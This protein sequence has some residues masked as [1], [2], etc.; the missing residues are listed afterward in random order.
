MNNPKYKIALKSPMHTTKF[1]EDENPRLLKGQI[2]IE[3][4]SNNIRKAKVGDG[5]N[6]WTDLPYIGETS[7]SINNIIKE[8]EKKADKTNTYTK[9]EVDSALDEKADKSNTYTKTEVNT[10]LAKK[11]DKVTVDEIIDTY[12]LKAETERLNS[13]FLEL[14][15]EISDARIV[16]DQ[17][18][19][20]LK[21]ALS[22]VSNTGYEKAKKYT[23]DVLSTYEAVDWV[24]VDG[25][26]E[27]GYPNI[28]NPS[29]S[30]FY[31]VSNKA[32]TG[33]DKYVWI[34]Y[35]KEDS[36]IDYKWDVF[37]SATTLVVDSLE[38]ISQ[39]SEDIDYI[40]NNNDGCLYYKYIDNEFV[41][42]GGSTA[43]FLDGSRYETIEVFLKEIAT[44]NYFTDYYIL[45]NQIY[46]H[47]RYIDDKWI[48]IN[49]TFNID[50]QIDEIQTRVS[51]LS[52]SV[53]INGNSI[54]DIQTQLES[55]ESG[56]EYELDL[57][58]EENE[59]TEQTINKLILKCDGVDQDTIV[60][61]S[62]G[63]SGG[64]SSKI[65]VDMITPSSFVV[66]EGQPALIEY[67]FSS[68]D[69]DGDF[70]AGTYL[71][72]IDNVPIQG[73][74][75][76]CITGLNSFDI[77]PYLTY[78]D[79]EFTLI[80]TDTIGSIKTKRWTVRKVDIRLESTFND[81]NTKEAGKNFEFTFTPY[82]AGIDKTVHF[83][84]DGVELP[85]STFKSSAVAQIYEIPAQQHGAHLLECWITAVINGITIET[86][87][88]Y[89]DIICVDST[90][91]I[92]IIGCS[93][94]CLKVDENAVFNENIVYYTM[95]KDGL[96]EIWNG[97][98]S[99]WETRPILYFGNVTANQYDSTTIEYVVY[100]PN[101][102]TSYVTITTDESS[103]V[104]KTDKL[105]NVISYKTDVAGTHTIKFSIG[106]ND[107]SN[108]YLIMKIM[109][110][111][112]EI[113][114]V[115]TGRIFDFNPSG[116]SNA[117]ID[118]N[119]PWH[120]SDNS[121]IK[122]TVSDGFD[123]N[124]G[125]FQLDE[126][127][128][129]YFCVKSGHR[130]Y[131]SHKL[132]E[133]D[134]RKNGSHFK[135][136]FKT[137]NV[138]NINA[139]F[140]S[141]FADKVGLEMKA[142]EAN[143]MTASKTLNIP[144]SEEDIIEFEYNV[145]PIDTTNDSAKA[146]IMIYEDGVP[147][148]PM[149]YDNTHRLYQNTNPS[150][151]TIGSDDCDI[152]IYRMKANDSSLNDKSVIL[153]FI[154]DALNSDEM[155]SRY[156]RNQ[157]YDSSTGILTPES[158]ANACPDLKIIKIECPR[159]TNNKSD[160]VK[161]TNI[162]CI[163]KGGDPILD[164]WYATGA[165][166]S[167][168][169]TTSNEYGIAGRNLDL[170]MNTDTTVITNGV[171][172]VVNG[173]ANI[174]EGGGIVENVSLTRNSVP[175]NYFNIKVNIASSENANNALLQKRFQRFLPYKTISKFKD[176]RVK[177]TMEFVNCVVFIK[178]TG[179]GLD[180][181]GNPVTRQEF[182]DDEWHFYAI[183]N[184]GDSKKTDKTRICDEN[185]TK[186]FVNE[187]LDN[188]FPNSIFD[189]GVYNLIVETLPEVG[190]L[191]VDYYT[192]NDNGLYTHSRYINNE[193]ITVSNNVS[194]IINGATAII[195]ELPIV[196][197]KLIDYYIDNGDNTYTMYVW[198]G[199]SYSIGINRDNIEKNH[200]ATAIAEEQWIEGNIKYDSLI[201]DTFEGKDG[202]TYEPRYKHKD[203][204]IEDIKQVWF[205]FYKWVIT[206]TDDAFVN[207]FD[208]WFIKD[209]AL[210]FYLFTERYTMMDNRAK[211]SFWHWS[212]VYISQSEAD[213]DYY[214]SVKEYYEIDDAKA[215]INNGYRF[216]FW[217]YD[218]DTALGINNSG[219][220]KM[221]YGKEDIDYHNDN[222]NEGYIFNGAESTIF[223]RMRQLMHNDLMQMYQNRESA[224]AWDSN[225]LINEFDTWQ[226]QFPEE[227]WRLDIE[228]KYMRP[229]LGISID[230]SIPKIADNFLKEM[231]NGRKKY[232]RRQFEREQAI[233]MATKYLSTSVTKDENNI[234]I[235]CTSPSVA[236]VLPDYTL[237]ITPYSDMYLSVKIGNSAATQ[238]RAKAGESYDIKCHFENMTETMVL[239]YAA[240]RIQ[241]L[242]DLSRCYIDANRFGTATKLQKLII[243]SDLTG[244]SNEVLNELNIS[245]AI[246][247]E[248][249]NITNCPK[250][251]SLN[252]AE[253][254]S[255]SKVYAE[256]TNITGFAFADNGK[257][258]EAYLPNGV[259]TLS[260]R[261]LNYIN[262]FDVS[263]DNIE[264]I[265]V[266]GG[267]F[268]TNFIANEV[269]DT[270]KEIEL[271][272]INW[273]IDN[274]SILASL[275]NIEKCY[276]SGI[277]T[278]IGRITSIELENYQNKWND[279]KID[280]SQATIIPYWTVM[281]KNEDGT[282]LWI[283]YVESG[284]DVKNPKFYLGDDYYTPTKI[285]DKK[286]KYEFSNWIEESQELT[287]GQI[288][289]EDESSF[290]P[291][292]SGGN[293]I[294]IAQYTSA[295]KEFTVTWVDGH[296]TTLD[297]VTVPYGTE[298]VWDFMPPIKD[299][300][301][302]KIG[303]G[304]GIPVY[305]KAED[306]F[307]FYLFKGWNKSTG[308]VTEDMTVTA[309]WDLAKNAPVIRDSS[310]ADYLNNASWV[311]IYHFCA[312]VKQN[313]D[314]NLINNY[315]QG[316]DRKTFRM[317]NDYTFDNV[318]QL[319]LITESTY[320]DGKTTIDKFGEDNI[321]IE[322]FNK[323]NDK[324][325]TLC[326]D[327]EYT[328][329]D[330]NAII[331][332]VA[333]N[334]TIPLKIQHFNN[335]NGNRL[336]FGS[337]FDTTGYST[338]RNMVVIRHIAGENKLYA[339]SFN[340]NKSIYD[341]KKTIIELTDDS[342]H[343][344]KLIL[345][346][347]K[348][349]DG[350]NVYCATGFIHKCKIWFDDLGDHVS[351]SICDWTTE[352]VVIKASYFDDGTVVGK[353]NGRYNL[354]N[355]EM[356]LSYTS[357][358]FEG[359]LR[360][361]HN[362]NIANYNYSTSNTID[363]NSYEYSGWHD[364][365]MRKFLNPEHRD[366]R[367][368]TYT[369]DTTQKYIG[370]MGRFYKGLP[371]QLRAL[372][373]CVKTYTKVGKQN[374]NVSYDYDY[375]YIPSY[376][377]VFTPSRE[378]D[379]EEIYSLEGSYT[380]ILKSNDNIFRAKFLGRIVP[381]TAKYYSTKSAVNEV[382]KC[383]EDPTLLYDIKKGDVWETSTSVYIYEDKLT[384]NKYN[385]IKLDA[386]GNPIPVNSN[387]IVANNGGLWISAS[388]WWE[389]SPSK[390]NN[391]SYYH[392]RTTGSNSSQYAIASSAYG[393]CPCFSIGP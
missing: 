58:E 143:Y 89:K 262:T 321:S 198:N 312:Y 317:G 234:M 304:N 190:E 20:N 337:S 153:N 338:Y 241:A 151:I 13:N 37:G 376:Y 342:I 331:M 155:I 318:S 329:P 57:I 279:L 119:N 75:G 207:E 256:G 315:I 14:V 285:D 179:V 86:N 221:P 354:F 361:T 322:L 59:E 380:N 82:G 310:D 319:D 389:R 226:A 141:C 84:L 264:S 352:N 301:G 341:D 62:G 248:E 83:V 393:I 213:S 280:T 165:S 355:N 386:N 349:S 182:Q 36:S 96:F 52:T 150:I 68:Q 382:I 224:D 178:E 128:N 371:I 260:M 387:D 235:R 85:S 332:S 168:Q 237:N 269:V 258:T 294:Y 159:F 63:G 113:T 139:T 344:G 257:L 243:G 390:S 244:Y 218:N 118:K 333:D 176:S 363:G 366:C 357:F 167:G 124:N 209:A 65:K 4:T 140:L 2:G 298:A 392:V 135:F 326:I 271:K 53:T 372:I 302:N 76:N 296:G 137:K 69:E 177:T 18:F 91:D 375:I 138:K 217:D 324:S 163:H 265:V 22:A 263:Y 26:T 232:H 5:V 193:W 222:R 9:T 239:I 33:Y 73:A 38:N 35:T 200:M 208:N 46:N 204:N 246:M 24:I 231:M 40:V 71:W 41:M 42:V 174:I 214:A 236:A 125:G 274:T 336:G 129:T 227:L 197:N 283:Q 216:D 374:E 94:R 297:T 369:V 293:I 121:D 131:I 353:V 282:L 30:T 55:I 122:L 181:D 145:S 203:A 196:G 384:C 67:N 228:R 284:K 311:D 11:A 72:K 126:N 267:N 185:D 249:L 359:L 169:G 31:L 10:E 378:S 70:L 211:N 205:N 223:R 300:L 171:T 364:T 183:G 348:D 152:C 21:E 17:Q 115:T 112:I 320:F 313:K 373:K 136:I 316:G 87:H 43:Q 286:Y 219:E 47:Y 323:E 16:E 307:N 343:S 7:D 365:Q 170:I 261:N 132:F 272:N 335:I 3:I 48:R 50:N 60:L 278:I 253:F 64:G 95:N 1:W 255:L 66:V 97:S 15:S 346:G 88:I 351:Q 290:A 51:N 314:P 108:I 277:V 102:G 101:S 39:P 146:I 188:T 92:P 245:G 110:L 295:I 61:P 289:K 103:V 184:I 175:N 305:T 28:E 391:S 187:I 212:K 117:S 105:V 360:C 201:A 238:I 164:N 54:A 288:Y 370:E 116:C 215:E 180:D 114:P 270:A 220:V 44:P 328:A 292:V 133:K 149:E 186:E 111:N 93:N 27:K 109:E 266:D 123:W 210:Y 29:T 172:D 195:S 251:T 275:Y 206:S 104:E 356:M 98:Y 362:M 157:I 242:N 147:Y 233:Y 12:A 156:T 154:A 189:T 142:H 34:E 120:D 158:L 306:V 107:I 385:L 287:N 299:E 202:E 80:V 281:F 377:E 32:G 106:E 161:G 8:L 383:T 6:L 192:L 273:T 303:G 381:E 327:Y 358:M 78:N 230:N 19:S 130:A 268:D 90:S 388:N 166:H 347:A 194:E 330:N 339:Y 250:I 259:T 379:I 254:K 162:Q 368:D 309:L 74:M 345:G 225:G 367:S 23:D 148:R 325:F 45:Y 350:N 79:R 144:Y 173:I 247:L 291:I 100:N 240:S 340:K 49:D 99:D 191:F 252:L 77:T 160:K 81:K 334:N 308:Y 229:Y 56:H 25:L 127:G 199:N 134:V 276:L